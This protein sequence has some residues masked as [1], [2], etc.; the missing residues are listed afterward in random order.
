MMLLLGTGWITKRK[1]I[2]WIE[3]V[4]FSKLNVNYACYSAHKS[5]CS[6]HSLQ[7]RRRSLSAGLVEAAPKIVLRGGWSKVGRRWPAGTGAAL[8]VR[9]FRWKECKQI[10]LKDE[11]VW[12]NVTRYSADSGLLSRSAAAST[13][14]ANATVRYL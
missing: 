9:P 13:Y 10:H 12:N 1:T 7:D 14:P 2:T 3:R 4:R 6:E 8:L 5:R 11:Q